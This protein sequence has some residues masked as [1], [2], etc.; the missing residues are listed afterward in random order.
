MV[1][2]LHNLL[3][4]VAVTGFVVIMCHVLSLAA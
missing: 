2:A 4:F 1:S 3:S